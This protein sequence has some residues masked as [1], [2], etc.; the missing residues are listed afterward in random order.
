LVG[1]Y[2]EAI[3]SFGTA[4]ARVPTPRRQ[5]VARLQRKIG[6]ALRIKGAYSEAEAALGR[7]R[8]ALGGESDVEMAQIDM[9]VG[10][11]YWRTGQYAAARDSLNEA[12]DIASELG[13]DEVLAEG[14]KQLG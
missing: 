14:L 3:T 10:Q 4:H 5:T 8:E 13:A 6:T 11:L 9:Q 7:A 1:R 2:D 12:V